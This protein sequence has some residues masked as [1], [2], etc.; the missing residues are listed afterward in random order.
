M[1]YK[2]E[3]KRNGLIKR[4][5]GAVSFEDVLKSEQEVASCPDFSTLRYVISDYIGSDYKGITEY[6]KVDI[7]ALRIGGHGTNP[8]I[9]YAFV[10]QNPEIRE[11]IKAAVVEGDLLQQSQIFDT[12]E[13]AAQWVG[14]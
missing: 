8:F 14:L 9:K 5:S 1:P 11:Q 10:I 12:Y 4:F 13:Q 7:N 3:R 6:Q 2:I